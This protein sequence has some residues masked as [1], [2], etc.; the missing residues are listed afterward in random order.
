MKLFYDYDLKYPDL[1]ISILEYFWLEGDFN[2]K[3]VIDFCTHNKY[4]VGSNY[5]QPQIILKICDILM[6][7]NILSQIRRG[8]AL[9]GD[10]SYSFVWRDSKD[11]WQLEKDL[12]NHI[13]CSLVY[14][15]NYIYRHYQDKVI[16]IV[17][18]QNNGKQSMGSSFK[19]YNGIVTA[20]H[21]IA[22]GDLFSIKGYTSSQLETAKVYVSKN[23]A[24]DIAYIETG[25]K[26]EAYVDTPQILDNILVMGYPKIPMFL[27]F[28][29]A[30]KASISTIA[31]W[32]MTPTN[33]AITAIAPNMYTYKDTDL[34][35]ITAQIKGGNSGGPI[36]NNRGCVV[37]VAFSEP[38]SEGE[39]YDDLGYGV[40]MPI[41]M[42]DNI[43][44]EKNIISPKFK[45]WT[46]ES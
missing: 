14:G 46:E 31:K 11:N 17:A 30:E 41:Q 42:L 44:S 33:G 15:F 4:N 36:I 38:L 12:Y 6:D 5:L 22:D 24:I 25:E 16:P 32:R 7:N 27:D 35:L 19:F 20:R 29:T 28:L 9:G 2:S 18:F 26:S 45:S 13:C 8:G 34:I 21:C 23:P 1:M 3:T 10:T 43:I 39:G 40:G 37:G